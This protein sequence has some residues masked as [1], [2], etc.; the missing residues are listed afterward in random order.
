MLLVLKIPVVYL[1]L[2]IWW[3]IRADPKP[4]EPVFVAAVTDT[5][6]ALGPLAAR[7]RRFR[8]GPERPGPARRPPRGRLT[9]ARAEA[10]R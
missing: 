6:P 8:R 9:H 2:V 3:A 7:D 4:E 10:R 5:P 1:G